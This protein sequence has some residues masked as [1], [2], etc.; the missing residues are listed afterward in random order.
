MRNSLN[1]CSG[2]I[3]ID[4]EIKCKHGFPVFPSCKHEPMKPGMYKNTPC[5]NDDTA[6]RLFPETGK[7]EQLCR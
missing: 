2:L 4:R 1:E 3:K 6:W 7:P 5:L